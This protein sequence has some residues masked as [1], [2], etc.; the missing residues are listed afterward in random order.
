MARIVAVFASFP[1]WGVKEVHQHLREQGETVSERQV[2]QAAEQSGWSRLR[3]ELVKRYQ[4]TAESIRPRDNWLVKQLLAQVESLLARVEAGARLTPEEQ[5]AVADLRTLAAEVGM[6][7]R[8]PLKAL[9]WMIG[10]ERV[11][12]GH[13]EEVSNGTVR[14]IY[15]GSTHVVCKSKKPR[16]KK[17]YDAEGNPQTVALVV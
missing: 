7:A 16:L 17:Y 1:W 15:C 12:F 6:V 11:V 13:R 10:V 8:P 9:P 3:Q 5:I 14:C 2:R 4:L